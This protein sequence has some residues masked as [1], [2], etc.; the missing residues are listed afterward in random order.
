LQWLPGHTN[1]PGNELADQ[2]AK[3]AAEGPQSSSPLKRL[4]PYLRRNGLLGSISAAIQAQR[5]LSRKR[6]S[7]AWAKSPRYKLASEFNA[8]LLS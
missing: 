6:W 5:D 2:E 8:G 7:A 1:I 4:P 3:K